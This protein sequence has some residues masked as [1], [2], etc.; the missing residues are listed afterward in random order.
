MIDLKPCPFCGGDDVL[1]HDKA[2]LDGKRF[3][4]CCMGGGVRG[5]CA[6]DYSFATQREAIKHWNTRAPVAEQPVDSAKNI[7]VALDEIAREYDSYE[8]GLPTHDF[9]EDVMKKM[10]EAVLPY[11]SAPKRESGEAEKIYKPKCNCEWFAYSDG[12]PYQVHKCKSKRI[13]GG[14]S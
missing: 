2:G 8:Y 13:E 4:I 7:I 10:I 14:E 5:C 6:Q 1:I 9:D 12:T 3:Y 11:L